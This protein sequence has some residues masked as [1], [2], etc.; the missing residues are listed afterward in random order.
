V[1]RQ[2]DRIKRA[3]SHQEDHPLSPESSLGQSATPPLGGETRFDIDAA[4]AF[5]LDGDVSQVLGQIL[6]GYQLA[7]QD[8]PSLFRT[9]GQT[10]HLSA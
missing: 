1:T 3:Q 5:G 4:S 2:L 6:E 10:L 9:Y 7:G 8:I